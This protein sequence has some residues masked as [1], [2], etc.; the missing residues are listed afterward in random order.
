LPTLRY[1]LSGKPIWQSARFFDSRKLAVLA[2]EASEA[3][4]R[5]VYVELCSQFGQPVDQPMIAAA[6]IVL[7]PGAVQADVQQVVEAHIANG[8]ANSPLLVMRMARS[9][10]LLWQGGRDV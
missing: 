7:Q 9:E 2:S 1:R 6:Q 5:E 8:L 4:E 10:Q 3:S